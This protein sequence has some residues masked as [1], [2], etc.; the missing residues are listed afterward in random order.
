MTAL[1]VPVQT[2]W[3]VQLTRAM[4]RRI[5]DGEAVVYDPVSGSTHYLDS[6]AAAVL[7][8]LSARPASAASVSRSLLAEFNADCE[9]D[10]LA[11]VQDALA[12]LRQMDLIQS[13]DV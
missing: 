11:A 1:S 13:A 10:M 5:W 9:A 2:I 6:V 8:R 7:D 12:K 3:S 4:L